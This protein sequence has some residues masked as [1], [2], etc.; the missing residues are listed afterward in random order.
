MEGKEGYKKYQ[1]MSEAYKDLVE[2]ITNKDLPQIKLYCKNLSKKISSKQKVYED[3]TDPKAF[4]DHF[5]EAKGKVALH[6]A[7]A[8]GDV[9]IVS[10][11]IEIRYNY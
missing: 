10:Y 8:R 4:L 6:Y 3:F 9:S 1:E 11:L 2:T 5:K 7:C